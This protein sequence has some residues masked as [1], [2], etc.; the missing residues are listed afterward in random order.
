MILTAEAEE[1]RLQRAGLH[2]SWKE[3]VRDSQA[4]RKGW[5]HKWTTLR[6]HW[7]PLVTQDGFSG[8]PLDLLTEESERLQDIWECGDVRAGWFDAPEDAWQEL[9]PITAREFIKAA[10]TFPCRTA[11]TWDGFHPKHF[12]LLR[13]DQC[14]VA[15]RLYQLK[16]RVSC[17]PTTMQAIYGKLIPK[18]KPGLARVSMR[19]IGLLPSLYRHWQRVR[20]PVARDWEAGAQRGFPVGPIELLRVCEPRAPLRARE[21]TGHGPGGGRHGS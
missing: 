12:G 15:I 16:E 8:R 5:A 13:E 14:V 17:T 3:W 11:Q 9:P 2:A 7:R 18:H 4:H 20:Q 21:A 10:N 6:Q 1:Q 19:S